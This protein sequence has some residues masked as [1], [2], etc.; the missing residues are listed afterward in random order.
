M[1]QFA[2]NKTIVM[3]QLVNYGL[4]S[5][6]DEGT[7]QMRVQFENS[8]EQ[9]FHDESLVI[10]SGLSS[11]PVSKS[12]IT[13]THFA[14]YESLFKNSFQCFTSAEVHF[15]YYFKRRIPDCFSLNKEDTLQFWYTEYFVLFPRNSIFVAQQ[16]HFGPLQTIL[17]SNTS[18]EVHFKLFFK[19]S[20]PDFS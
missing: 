17:T 12:W 11:S 3:N 15:Q 13:V 16:A 9:C 10:I 19:R 6:S 20:I 4:C 2:R 8:L 1:N 18:A 14:I 5:A 7:S